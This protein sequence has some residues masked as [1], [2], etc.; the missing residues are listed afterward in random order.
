MYGLFGKYRSRE[1]P[2][3]RLLAVNS[4]ER[5][6]RSVVVAVRWIYLEGRTKTGFPDGLNERYERE[7]QKNGSRCFGE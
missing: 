1:R 3:R 2:V 4:G 6:C 5:E 7:E